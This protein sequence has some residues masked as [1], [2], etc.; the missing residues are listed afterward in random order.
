LFH[1]RLGVSPCVSTPRAAPRRRH[2]VPVVY[3]Y[4]DVVGVDPHSL[5]GEAF[6]AAW[7]HRGKR[8]DARVAAFDLC[9][10][11][12]KSVSLQAAG[13]GTVRRAEV[14]AARGDRAGCRSRLPGAH[15]VGVRREHNGT[16]RYLADGGLLA[17]AFEHRM[18]R[19]GHPQAH[20]HV[21]VENAALGPD[22]R[23]SALDS[24]R[25]YAHL[26]AADHLYLTVERAEL[27]RRLDV[28]WTAVDPRS[29]A[30][31]VVG[32]DDRERLRQFSR[33]SEEIDDW[34]TEHGPA[35]IK[36]SCGSG[37]PPTQAARGVGG[38]AVWE[39]GAGRTKLTTPP[40]H[41]TVGKAVLNWL[42]ERIA[43]L[44]GFANLLSQEFLPPAEGLH[45]VP[46]R[47]AFDVAQL[48][49]GEEVE[50]VA[51]Q[52][53]I[54]LEDK[55]GAER[56][57]FDLPELSR[58]ESDTGVLESIDYTIALSAGR[59][60]VVYLPDDDRPDYDVQAF[61][62]I[63]PGLIGRSRL[64]GDL[65]NDFGGAVNNAVVQSP[66]HCSDGPCSSA[67]DCHGCVECECRRFRTSRMNNMRFGV[68]S[69]GPKYFACWCAAHKCR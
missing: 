62:S 38:A 41:S 34:L 44:D 22:G 14:A 59:G 7:R 16:D 11:S 40:K 23:W 61:I 3:Q 2:R 69:W 17:V 66:N 19:A 55:Y 27:T 65:P 49:L 52:S 31:E 46:A 42:S 58:P 48:Y 10:S 45:T 9:F 5:Y 21:L 64:T 33:R 43:S 67:H 25:L 8:I 39:R 28:R 30:A 63:R 26:M 20:V 13:G 32:L 37:H 53:F 24:D 1:P 29:G 56:R 54:V 68:Q 6:A 57:L 35:G 50:R 51:D 60:L 47:Q 12:P 4:P 18:S 36:A 15:A